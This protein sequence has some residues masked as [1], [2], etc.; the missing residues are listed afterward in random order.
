MMGFLRYDLGYALRALVRNPGFAIAAVATLAL[1]IGA[2]TAI[3][4][5]AY[6]VSVR[7][8]PY[9]NPE[10]LVRIYEANPANGQPEHE[11]SMGAFHEWRE[12][13]TSLES[14]ALFGK[15]GVRFLAGADTVPVTTR[16][17]SPAF[18]DVLGV[19]P[20]LGPGFKTEKEYTRFTADAEGVLSFDAWQRLLGGRP[21]V[22]G[23]TIAFSGV[24][25]DDV[26]RIVGV[27]PKDFA[28]EEPTDL[29]RPSQIVQQP[30][31]RLLR[32]WRYE[33]VVA[34]L[35]P[36]ATIDRARAELEAVGQRLAQDFPAT[37]AGWTASIETLHQ[38]IVGNFGRATWLLLAAV[39][40]V[41]L[42]TCLNVGGLLVARA[43]ARERETAVRV[44]LGAGTWRLVRLWLA[45][46][47]AI[48]FIEIGRAHV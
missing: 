35:R 37:N 41:L 20:M 43:V 36:E 44:A 25:D 24:G 13:V 11:V 22:I 3:F 27:M 2:S 47:S 48:G 42:V 46:A 7:P 18:F 32:L 12:R 29:W 38:A 10:R 26:Y 21:D 19:K 9:G 1:G 30:V 45:E 40:V 5:V 23:G 39:G 33:H 16:S 8:L 31:P 14:I 17:V 6:G 28:F 15:R 4:S 34:R